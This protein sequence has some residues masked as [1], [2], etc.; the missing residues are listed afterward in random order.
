MSPMG[1]LAHLSWRH[2]RA[3]S[4]AE[5]LAQGWALH[6]KFNHGG[7]ACP[8]SQL[9]K[10]RASWGPEPTSR[11]APAP[12]GV[13]A[14]RAGHCAERRR[15]RA[16]PGLGSWHT[17]HAHVLSMGRMFPHAKRVWYPHQALPLSRKG[18]E[19]AVAALG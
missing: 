5:P 18:D 8:L 12:A 13:A 6:G 9:A 11:R 10:T 4:R 16:H 3:P 2:H 15:Y 17:R 14:G 19:Y 7:C 1:G